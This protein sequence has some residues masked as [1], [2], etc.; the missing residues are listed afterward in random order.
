MDQ[1]EAGIEQAFISYLRQR[2][3]LVD[4]WS[5]KNS[6]IVRENYNNIGQIICIFAV[7]VK[8][9]DADTKFKQQ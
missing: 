5:A 6:P 8:D 9:G 1:P 2:S 4:F 3:S 7:F